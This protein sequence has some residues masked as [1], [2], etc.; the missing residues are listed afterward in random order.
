MHQGSRPGQA[1][2][3]RPGARFTR[4]EGDGDRFVRQPQSG[5]APGPAEDQRGQHEPRTR[6]RG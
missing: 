3:G 4:S 5:R 1:G 2:A 6:C